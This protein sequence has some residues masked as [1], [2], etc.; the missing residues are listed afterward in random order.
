MLCGDCSHGNQQQQLIAKQLYNQ[1]ATAPHPPR[2]PSR[3]RPAPAPHP[4]ETRTNCCGF[5]SIECSHLSSQ[6]HL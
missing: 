5:L 1:R 3:H 6:N 4:R 2:N